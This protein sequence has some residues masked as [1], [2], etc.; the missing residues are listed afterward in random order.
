MSFISLSLYDSRLG[1]LLAD[2]RGIRVALIVSFLC[3][4]STLYVLSLDFLY[5]LPILG[6]ALVRGVL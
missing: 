2:R 1:G 4:I 3:G 6:L 5:T